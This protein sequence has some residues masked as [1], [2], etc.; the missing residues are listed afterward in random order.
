M[1]IQ[2][3]RQDIYPEWTS[4]SG[5]EFWE[6]DR[7]YIEWLTFLYTIWQKVEYL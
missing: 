3:D 4:T 5:I 7:L 2:N 1:M 6:P